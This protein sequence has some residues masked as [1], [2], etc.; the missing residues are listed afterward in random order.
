MTGL[1]PT[2]EEVDDFLRQCESSN[3]ALRTPQSAIESL[4]DRLLASERYGERWARHW[5]DLVR[6]AD[7][8]SFERDGVKPNAWRYRDYVIRSFNADK[9]Y[10]QFIREQLAGDELTRRNT[11]SMIATGY[12]RLG[13]WDDEP[14]DPL[15]ALYDELDDI[16]STTGQVFLGLTI[17]CARCHDHKIDP[18]PQRDYY[19][20]LAFF[21]D[22][23]SYG[24]RSDQQSANQADISPPE[25]AAAHAEHDRKTRQ[26][27]ELMEPIEQRGIVKM[28]AEDQRKTETR[29]RERVLR[30]KLKDFL[31]DA[32]WAEYSKLRETWNRLKDERLP[33]RE[34]ALSVARTVEPPETYVFNRGNPHVKKERVTPG[35][36]EIFETPDPDIRALSRPPHCAWPIGSCRP[37]IASR[38]G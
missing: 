10:D 31:S 36:P 3:S 24:H 26:L 33:P 4:V 17:N 38:R 29:E 14:A 20:M 19:R 12:Y 25:V 35:F 37:T 8:N 16:V 1:P 21:H 9:P 6:Y 13:L 2:P 34:M 11:E 32:D 30:E 7:T 5:L 18:I 27:R 23:T 22:L 15:Q 28:P